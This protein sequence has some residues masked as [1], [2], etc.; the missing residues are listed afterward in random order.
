MIYDRWMSYLRDDVRLCSAVIPGAHNA[1]TRGMTAMAC[2]QDGTLYEQ[3]KYGV[4]HFCIRT[5]TRRGRIVMC[6]GISKGYDFELAAE[7]IQRMIEEAP[8]EFFIF[9]IREY[10]DQKIGPFKVTHS[11]EIGKMNAFIKEYMSPEKY[12]LTEFN[13]ISEVTMGD[14]RRSGKRYLL[15]NYNHN[16]DHSVACDYIFPWD[17]EIYGMKT[18][19]FPEHALTLFDKE[20]T[21]GIYWF[22]TQQTPNLGTHVGATTP[23]RLNRDLIPYF[24]KFTDGIARNPYYLDQANVIAGDFMTADYSKAAQILSLNINKGN[25]SEDKTEEFKQGLRY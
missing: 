3:Y 17:K 25:I 9:D 16:Y 1:G 14:I 4:R 12:A 24:G 11:P 13:S 7:D 5:S 19:D 22:Q 6:H 21:D 2:C 15:Y 20:H 23:R 10:Y 8:T 18:S